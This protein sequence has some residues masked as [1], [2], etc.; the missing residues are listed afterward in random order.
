MQQILCVV[1]GGGQE[2]PGIRNNNYVKLSFPRKGRP[3]KEAGSD[4]Q[5]SGEVEGIPGNAS[6]PGLLEM[7]TGL[8]AHITH[9]QTNI[10]PLPAPQQQ[11]QEI[12][13]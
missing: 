12:A 7:D 4:V 5:Q 9:T 1:L 3:E 13:K 10:L 2:G 6:L 8:W 11:V